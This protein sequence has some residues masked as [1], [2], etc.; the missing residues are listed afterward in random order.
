MMSLKSAID[1]APVEYWLRSRQQAEAR[2]KED[3]HEIE[4]HKLRGY[5][6][7]IADILTKQQ[8]PEHWHLHRTYF[9]GGSSFYNFLVFVYEK[10]FN[11]AEFE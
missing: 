7:D 10:G 8:Y 1:Y 11:V 6:D 4:N 2:H 9:S 5:L 3:A